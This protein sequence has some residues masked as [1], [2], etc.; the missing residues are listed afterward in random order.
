M[1]NEFSGMSSIGSTL[2]DAR[3]PLSTQ[4]LQS[5]TTTDTALPVNKS[6]T[7]DATQSQQLQTPQGAAQPAK[8]S[9]TASDSETP[10]ENTA[11]SADEL[12]EM[13]DEI[14]STLYSMNKS[15]RFEV[16][17]KTDDLI[18]RVVNTRTDEVI[19]QYPSEE[20]L[21]RKERLLQGETSA[22]SARVD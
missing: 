19:R 8:E 11:L 13:L 17:D 14:N 7:L 4:R 3:K 22:F 15:L 5:S 18:V 9:N 12:R 6:Q 20:V 10:A 1:T 2:P 16:H 21:E